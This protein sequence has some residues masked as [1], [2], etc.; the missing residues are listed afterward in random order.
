MAVK[1]N[2]SDPAILQY[3]AATPPPGVT[4]NFTHPDS[5]GPELV[6]GGGVLLAIMMISITIRVYTKLHII[7][8]FSWD[9]L[10]I[11]LS[12]LGS[13]ALYGACI[14]RGSTP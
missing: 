10:T 4:P 6:V 2:L 5:K 14:W 8:K 3:P 7:N 1:L 13:I 11:F 9:D 12:A